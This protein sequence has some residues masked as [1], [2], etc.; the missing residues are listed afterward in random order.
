M[1]RTLGIIRTQRADGALNWGGKHE[2][3]VH[4][5]TDAFTFLDT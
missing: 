4:L 1:R 5:P 3:D 2:I